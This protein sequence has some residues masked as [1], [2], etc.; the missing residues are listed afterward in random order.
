VH[1]KFSFTFGKFQ[2][3]RIFLIIIIIFSGYFR[4]ACS[5]EI[6]SIMMRML[7]LLYTYVC[8]QQ[9]KSTQPAS[10]Q[11]MRFPL[12]E[13][14]WDEWSGLKQKNYSFIQVRMLSDQKSGCL[15]GFFLLYIRLVL[16]TFDSIQEQLS[17]GP[18][19]CFFRSAASFE[20]L[21][22]PGMHWASINPFRLAS[23]PSSVW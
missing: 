12:G 19:F 14:F 2:N 3:I 7:G 1:S 9:T 17:W 15:A 16:T 22:I 11:T 10:K 23:D 5:R 20:S 8:I 6:V 4:L 21:K 18:T 13:G